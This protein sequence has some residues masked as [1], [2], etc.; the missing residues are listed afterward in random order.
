M[1]TI[2]ILQYNLKDKIFYSIVLMAIVYFSYFLTILIRVKHRLHQIFP[3]CMQT[4]FYHNASIFLIIWILIAFLKY[5][6]YQLAKEIVQKKFTSKELPINSLERQEKITKVS[7]Y[8]TKI[9]LYAISCTIYYKLLKGTNFHHW[10][11]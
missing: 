10:T 6:M 2:N 5:S 11:L 7:I 9:S 8:L 4:D 1:K 3:E